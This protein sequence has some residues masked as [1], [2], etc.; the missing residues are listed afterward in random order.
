MRNR[1]QAAGT[2]LIEWEPF[3]GL[4]GHKDPEETMQLQHLCTPHEK[5][6]DRFKVLATKSSYGAKK[7]K[8]STLKSF[9]QGFL[10]ICDTYNA[11]SAIL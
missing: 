9:S 7:E 3:K 11:L 10:S 8:K 4:L 5:A 2:S 6:G 1:G